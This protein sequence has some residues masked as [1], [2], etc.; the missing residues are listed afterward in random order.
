[1]IAANISEGLLTVINSFRLP[2]EKKTFYASDARNLEERT[3]GF[4]LDL[5]TNDVDLGHFSF[6]NP[7][8][9]YSNLLFSELVVIYLSGH[10]LVFFGAAVRWLESYVS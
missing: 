1:M 10:Y 7:K 5:R 4:V 9:K 3:T 2:K 8:Q 6:I